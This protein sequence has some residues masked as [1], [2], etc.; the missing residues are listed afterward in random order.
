VDVSSRCVGEDGSISFRA[1]R[2]TGVMIDTSVWPPRVS[3]VTK[4]KPARERQQEIFHIY[5]GRV[6]WT[7]ELRF[8]NLSSPW[9]VSLLNNK[10]QRR[11]SVSSFA[12]GRDPILQHSF[13]YVS[14]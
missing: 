6:V 13:D 5:A 10:W 7:S 8:S 2:E 1:V 11:R 9:C 4:T 14:L 3:N 12:S